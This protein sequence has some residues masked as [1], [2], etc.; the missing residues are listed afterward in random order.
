MF[1]SRWQ[2]QNEQAQHMGLVIAILIATL[3]GLQLEP[4]GLGQMSAIAIIVA[5]AVRF[6][7]DIILK[8]LFARSMFGILK[9]APLEISKL[10]ESHL[11]YRGISFYGSLEEASHRFEF[12]EHKLMMVIEPY[13]IPRPNKKPLPV[14]KVSFYP[15][16]STN[17]AFAA[18]LTKAIDEIV[19]RQDSTS[20]INPTS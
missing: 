15:L 12:P 5:F 7:L 2:K 6:I 16:S 17:K 13:L 11:N 14:T 9:V 3:V 10:L 8:N 20:N 18:T 1:F 19:D 4:L